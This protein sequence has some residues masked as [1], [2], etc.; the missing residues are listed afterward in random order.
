MMTANDSPADARLITEIGMALA[1]GG[2]P[3]SRHEIAKLVAG[4]HAQNIGVEMLY[5]VPGARYADPALRFHAGA[6]IV[7]WSE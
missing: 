7:D 2:L 1:R 6:R 3:V 4:Y 5:A